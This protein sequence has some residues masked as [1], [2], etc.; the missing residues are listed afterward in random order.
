MLTRRLLAGVSVQSSA[1]WLRKTGLGGASLLRKS[2]IPG[3]RRLCCPPQDCDG[4]VSPSGGS[5][6]VRGSQALPPHACLVAMPVAI[7][8]CTAAVV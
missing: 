8:L 7:A 4:R 6:A 5:I 3:V 2:G 1:S